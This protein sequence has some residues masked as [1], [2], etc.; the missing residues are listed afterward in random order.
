[1]GDTARSPA[2][3]ISLPQGGGALRGIGEKF[4]PDPVTGTGSFTVPVTVPAGRGGL[5]PNLALTYS[6]GAGNGHFGLGWS[7]SLP[8]ISRKTSHGVPRY[9]D[10]DVFILSGHE[11]LVPLPAA[12]GAPVRYRPRTEGLFAE[13]V[14]H[15][16]PRGGHWLVRTRDGMIS[17]YGTP[18]PDSAADDW[19]DPAICADADDPRRVFSWQLTETR[20]P[21]GNLIR[22]EYGLDT[23]EEAGHRWRQPVLRTI[24][25]AD[26]TLDDGQLRFLARLDL[27]YEARPD[28]FS[29]YRSGFEIRTGLRCRALTTTVDDSAESP[30][31]RYELGYVPSAHS[32]VSLLSS[33][34]VVGFDD[35][36]AEHRDLPPVTFGYTTFEPEH[37]SFTAVT[38]DDPPPVPLSRSD[39]ELVD[40]TGDGLPDAVQLDGVARYWRNLGRGRFDR[41]RTLGYVPA[42]LRLADPGVQLLDAD[43]DARADLLVSTPTFVGTV[44]L[45]ADAT[46]AAIRPYAQAPTFSLDDP[47]IRLLDLNGDGVTDAVRVSSRLECYNQDPKLGWTGPRPARS[48]DPAGLPNISLTDPR[49]RWADMTGDG[50]QD[51]V[52]VH[53]TAIEYWPN[54]GHGR[55]G[56]RVA[57]QGAPRL[58]AR[59]DP[60]QLLLGDVDGDG[61]AD[62]VYVGADEVTVWI[63][64]CGNGW[65]SPITIRGCP[66]YA[67]DSVRIVDLHGT[68]TGGLLWSSDRGPSMH[69]LDLTGGVKP[70]LLEEM[71][72]NIGLRTRVRYEPSTQHRLRDEAR[73]R[74]RWRTPMPFVVPVVAAVESLDLI[75]G[76]KLT[77]EYHYHH[78]YWDGQEREFRGFGRVDQFDTA[79]F[80]DYHGPGLHPDHAVAALAPEEFSPRT[81]T[82][83][84]YHL[85]PA[86]LTGDGQWA[87]LDCR[88]EY[89]SGD[90]PLL[91]S[92]LPDPAIAD[93]RARRAALRSLRGRV[94][95]SEL[96]AHDDSTLRERPYTVTEYSYAVRP[97]GAPDDTRE[98]VFFPYETARRDTLW[99]RGEDPMTHFTYTS[100]HDG[101]GQP[102]RQ[103]TVVPPRRSACRQE[104]TAAVVGA[105]RP[106][107]TRVLATHTTT[108]YAI[109][110]T[111]SGIHDRV[112]QTHTYELAAP[113]GI[114]ESD[115][116]NVPSVLA[117]QARACAAVERLFAMGDPGTVRLI[118]HEVRHYDGAAF[119]GL[120]CG[121]VGAHGLLTRTRTLVHTEDSLAVGYL[122]RRPRYL[123]GAAD[124]PAGVPASFRSGAGLHRDPPGPGY[125]A[126]WYAQTECRA[127]DVQFGAAQQR[128]IVLQLRDPLGHL[129]AI[130]PDRFWL[131]PATV[132]DSARLRTVAT[133]NY[134]TGRPEKVTDPN[135]TTRHYRYHPLG[136]LQLMFLTGPGGEGGTLDKPEVRY[137]YDLSAFPD[138]GQPL[139]VRTISRIRHA[140]EGISD[141]TI[142]VREYSDGAGRQVQRQAQADDLAFGASGDDTGLPAGGP[143]VGSRAADRICVTGSQVYDNKGRVISRYEPFLA[144][145]WGYRPQE[146]AERGRQARFHYDPCGRTIRVRNPDGSERRT[147]TGIPAA[148]T[149]PTAIWP[150]PWATTSYDENDLAPDTRDPA[151][152]PLTGA[153]PAAHHHTP[154]LTLTDGLGR[155][156]CQLVHGGQDPDHD[157]QLTRTRHDTRGNLL[158]ITDE[159]GR[160]TFSCAYDLANRPVRTDTMDTGRRIAVADAA[161]NEIHT[162]DSRDH[163]TLRTYDTLNRLSGVY[164]A[165]GPGKA[166]TQRERLT[167]GDQ[168]PDEAGARQHHRLGQLWRHL[169][170]A[171][172]LL[173]ESYDFT[174]RRTAWVRQVVSDAAL[175][176]AEPD[177]WTADWAATDAEAALDATDYRSTSRYDALGRVIAT[178]TPAAVDDRPVLIE[179]TY[180][181]SGSLQS[182]SVDGVLYLRLI[183][184]NARGQRVLMAYGNGLMRRHAYDR[185]TFRQVRSRLETAVVDGDKWTGAGPALSDLTYRYDLVGNVLSIEERTTGCGIAGT[186]HG[187][188][189]LVRDFTH[190][191]Y[192][193]LVSAT[194]RACADIGVPRPLPDRPRC[195]SYPAAPDQHNAPE[196]TTG[197]RETY[198]YDPAGNLIDLHYQVTTGAQQPSWHRR[199][200]VGNLPPENSTQ[201]PHNRL[202]SVTEGAGGT[203][204][205]LGYDKAGNLCTQGD[206]RTYTWDHAS[207]LTGFRCHAGDTSSITARYLYGA[208]GT[209]VKKWVRHQD[210]AG[211]DE[212]TSYP[213]PGVEHHR[214]SDAGGGENRVLHIMDGA[215]RVAEIRSGP[216]RPG[217]AGPEVRY[218]YADHLGSSALTT[219]ASRSWINR[220]EFFPYGETS[221][222]SYARK[223]YRFTGHERDEESGL[224][225]HGTRYYLPGLARWASADP[226]VSREMSHAYAYCRGRPLVAVDHSGRHPVVLLLVMAV[227]LNL[228]IENTANAPKRG[229]PVYP[230]MTE[231][232]F[233]A[234]A[235]LVLATGKLGSVIEK[236]IAFKLGGGVVGHAAGGFLG[237]TTSGLVGGP[238]SRGVSDLARGKL[239]SGAEYF[240][241]A[242]KTG[243]AGGAI[244]SLFGAFNARADGA[245]WVGRPRFSLNQMAAAADELSA[246]F[247]DSVRTWGENGWFKNPRQNPYKP[248]PASGPP[249]KVSVAVS[250][251]TGNV[252]LGT[253]AEERILAHP[254]MDTAFA[255]ME[256]TAA[257][258]R[259]LNQCAEFAA[260]DK[261]LW[262]G[263]VAED[264][265]VS[266]RDVKTGALAPA[267][268]NCQRTGAGVTFTA[269]MKPP[270]E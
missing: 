8:G 162:A 239:S 21:M 14:H 31:R 19:S 180:G 103:T 49:V 145:G 179:P 166:L 186:T 149:T 125:L 165:E 30:V 116:G 261:A 158:E 129:T 104:L 194:G 198:R 246:K 219:N 248:T 46:W 123:G 61:L 172:L 7:L 113:P 223:R 224:N 171:G 42:G 12:V 71:D 4:N 134:R 85:G 167:Y 210:Q 107:E 6:T 87:P 160:T 13:I 24:R 2:E 70:R 148:R 231:A 266:V 122:D 161:G 51:L 174:G 230:A 1:M 253:S 140:S 34:T 3:I 73:P 11:D 164:A 249:S 255:S 67:A 119:T 65:S 183:A 10:S 109:P 83:T 269:G 26:H 58:P 227:L 36:G 99:E 163:V 153:A 136:L 178:H 212:S 89:W 121:K 94:L 50:S 23:G 150:T 17:V 132:E 56:C 237:G 84:W 106:D 226:V 225:H 28:P 105:V 39:V 102:R 25:Y 131:L 256:G 217:D 63:N 20:D 62:L 114:T 44:P 93:R 128:G 204:L 240:E 173:A 141:D 242:W 245:A 235:A 33:V 218:E 112:A 137:V 110:A 188:D 68:G 151:G 193:R 175:A 52:L 86:D 90:P 88:D 233:A 97:E 205:P 201:A 214:W 236:Q 76:T 247:A 238:A 268:H 152:D 200:G 117:E 185:D 222:G 191:A 120:D 184:Y 221:F 47:E 176:A 135:G 257:K 232:E 202:T 16:G 189:H 15:R 60:R 203:P 100:D 168:D 57:M 211:R 35:D 264:L 41:P 244:G 78:G 92:S 170:E 220:E 32:G 115:P 258:P 197:Y 169:D 213:A 190:D 267:C 157:G 199:I 177:G 144:T 196:V 262:A 38:G 95:R 250:R 74:T 118:G 9:D 77:S 146:A 53:G 5:E 243:L 98:P 111:D 147:L 234:Q 159:H 69:F 260:V 206:S 215:E 108:A 270:R 133:Y 27:T 241:T 195:G 228:S 79:V 208:D 48:A 37:R 54:L 127:Y 187:R 254:D 216:A 81:E 64:R 251:K 55:W 143:A 43:G 75:S 142:E 80:D 138:T 209:R 66:P 139:C 18:P 181:R 91:Q 229:D 22:Y 182:I 154:T 259:A 265:V 126:G 155:P 263:E 82:R 96:Y 72:N 156:L 45:R 192:Y 207:R 29:N 124:L 252:Y 101:H 59:H 130:T 40:V